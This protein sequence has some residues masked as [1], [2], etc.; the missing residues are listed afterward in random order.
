MDFWIARVLISPARVFEMKNLMEPQSETVLEFAGLQLNCPPRGRRHSLLPRRRS[1]VSNVAV[2]GMVAGRE[3]LAAAL[4]RSTVP[5]V[6]FD[7]PRL[8]FGASN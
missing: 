6:V 7:Q 5:S 2:E 4:S 3:S 8:L 1:V